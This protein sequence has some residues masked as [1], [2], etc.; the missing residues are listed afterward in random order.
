MTAVLK[1]LIVIGVV[2]LLL[3]LITMFPA[4]IAYSWFAPAEIRLSGIGG[5][6]WSGAA[7]E[8]DAAGLYIRNLRWNFKP[9]AL[10]SGKLAFSTRLDPASGFMSGDIYLGMDGSILFKDL[11]AA[12]PISAFQH[13]VQV[14]G[15]DGRIRLQFEELKLSDGRPVA[16]AGTVD[17][18][19]LFVRGLAATAIGDYQ[20]RF[21]TT[22][23]GILASIEDTGGFFNIAGTL[24][25]SPDSLYSLTGL[26]APT[27]DT[28]PA[29]IDQLRFLG[30]ANDRGQR[31]F[32]FEGEL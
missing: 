12:A 14:P 7:T 4:R 20:A 31:E 19:N 21:S 6:I 3:G 11:D 5:T 23:D 18:T 32:R 28:P 15:L 26:I 16:A 25:L 1:R 24:K 10:L 17:I 2:T 27:Q 9:L 8:A 30:S 22:T 13:I 29:V